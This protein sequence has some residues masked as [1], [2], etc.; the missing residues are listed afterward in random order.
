MAA[1]GDSITAGVGAS[2]DRFE[3]APENTWTTGDADDEVMSHYERL[4]AAGAPIAGRNDN[5][6]I[7]G[8]NMAD[9]PDQARRTVL[10]G[11]AYVTIL[12]GANDVCTSSIETMTPVADFE[13]DFRATLDILV[14]GLPQARMFVVSVPDIQ[15]LWESFEESAVARQVWHAAGTCGAL[16]HPTNTQSERDEARARNLAFNEILARVCAEEPRCRF[17]GNAVFDYAFTREEVAIDF[18]HP[19]HEGH[20]TLAEL[21]WRYGYWPDV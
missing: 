13:R 4:L 7:P 21:T 14:S 19:S 8:A 6:A 10:S 1:I 12:L 17:D 3:A 5:F 9:G 18:F 16:L 11:A 20:R 2:P 15:R